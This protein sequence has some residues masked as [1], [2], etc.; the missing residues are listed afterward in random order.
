V[1]SLCRLEVFGDAALVDRASR[2]CGVD[3]GRTA[4]ADVPLSNGR[5]GTNYIDRESVSVPLKQGK[6]V[7]GRPAM[8]KKLGAPIFSMVVPLRD[9]TGKVTARAW[10]EAVVQRTPQA[11]HPDAAGLDPDDL[12]VRGAIDK[13]GIDPEKPNPVTV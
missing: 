11:L 5:I 6:T 1:R 12:P 13:F 2:V 10:A 7:I 9:A 8:G 3:V 4:I